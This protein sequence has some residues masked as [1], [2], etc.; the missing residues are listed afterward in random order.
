MKELWIILGVLI[1]VLLLVILTAYIC[2]RIAFF[3]PKKDKEQSEQFKLPE[4]DG[5]LPYH[6]LI[7]SWHDKLTSLPFEE[8]SIKTFDGLTL[9]ARYYECQKGAPIE[10]MFHGYRG[11]AQRD[12]CGG[13]QR[14][15]ALKRN[16]LLVDQRASSKSEGNVITFGIKES[17]DCL[18]WVHYLVERFGQDYV[19]R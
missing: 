6:D 10:L 1:G 5:F 9:Y 3:V 7:K 14:S 2:F 12:L 18:C 15:F 8:V 19:M 11:T 17:K 16:V 4:G 13:I